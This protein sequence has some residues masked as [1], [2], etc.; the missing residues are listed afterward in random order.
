MLLA[1]G[2]ILGPYEVTAK[3][4]EGGMGEVYRARDTKLDRDVALKVLPQAFTDDPDRLARFER[5]AKVLASLNHPNIGGIHGLEESD[6]VRALVLEY[7]DGPTLADRIALGPIPVDEALPIAKQIAEALEAAHEAGVIHRDLKPANIKVRQD[8]TVKVLD[9]G[10]AKAL[11]TT[12]EGDP[13]L[14]PTL[15]AA[16]TQMG[17]IMGTAAYMSPE[18]ARGKPVDKRADIWAFGAVLF[19][20]LTGKRAFEGEDISLTL[21]D[22]M[23]AEPDWGRLP[24]ELSP[25]LRTFLTRCLAKDAKKRV[26][27]IGDMSLAMEGAFETTVSASPAESTA[28]QPAGWPQSLPLALGALL[29]GSL[30]T[31]IAVWSLRPGPP[32]GSPALFVVSAAPSPVPV[33]TTWETELTISPD[34]RTVVYRATLDGEDGLYVRPVDQLEGELLPGTAGAGSIFFSPDGTEIGFFTNVDGTLKKIRVSGGP[35]TTLC[36]MPT[37]PRGASWGPEDI[38]FAVTGGGNGLLRVSAAGGE[39]E[40]LTTPEP[41]QSHIWPD[42]LPGGRAVLFTIAGGAGFSITGESSQIAVLNLETGEQHVLIE[43]GSYP[44]YLSSGHLVYRRTNTLWAVGFDADRLEVVTDPIPVLEEVAAP[45]SGGTNV[46][47]SHDGTLVYQQGGVREHLLVWVDRDGREEPIAMTPRAYNMPRISPDGR[48]LIVDVFPGVG[49]LWL[50]EFDTGVEEQFTSAPGADRWPIWSPDGADIFFGSNREGGAENIWVKAADSSGDPER[51]TSS[52]FTQ[53]PM[54]W[55]AD[56]HTLV[57]VEVDSATGSDIVTLGMGDGAGAVQKLVHTVAL[58]WEAAI[59][60]DG[61]WLAFVSGEAGPQ[62]IHVRSFPDEDSGRRVVGNG[63]EPLWG[64]DGRELF[65]R[66]GEAV[67]V[68]QV[69]QVEAGEAFGRG[70]ARVLFPDPYHFGMGQAWDISADG[71]RFL[72]VKDVT[73]AQAIILVQNFDEELTRLFTDQ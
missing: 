49:D 10:L 14:S 32:L 63:R 60:P 44:R 7:I 24:E 8:G 61:R 23:R 20:M 22:V 43:G 25:A 71:Q 26:R 35:T 29:V 1:P 19:E 66:N 17:V 62:Q 39:P 47:I 50:Y 46:D 70:S 53:G 64:P 2:T 41:P 36:P 30:V 48:R 73:K 15:T 51:L 12:P 4:G 16:A 5:E 3:I 52:P 40:T 31:G 55:S 72:M 59:S 33:Q 69:E 11:D 34:G 68:V 28:P 42:L 54:D 38:I 6:G 65:Y 58:E 13:S 21:A 9:F 18:Q 45:N 37:A 56:G 57:A 27:D 67:M